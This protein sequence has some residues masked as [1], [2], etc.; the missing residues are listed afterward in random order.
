MQHFIINPIRMDSG[1]AHVG[2]FTTRAGRMMSVTPPALP[3]DGTGRSTRLRPST[4]RS[5]F[6]CAVGFLLMTAEHPPALIPAPHPRARPSFHAAA[7]TVP[8]APAA[9]RQTARRPRAGLRCPVS[10]IAG[11][12]RTAF[13]AEKITALGANL[14]SGHLAQIGRADPT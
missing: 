7:A 3:W 13:C 10:V 9:L 2:R 4:S 8:L 12:L 5:R 6:P 14:R 1:K 11:C